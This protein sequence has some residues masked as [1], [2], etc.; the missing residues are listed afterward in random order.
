MNVL[1]G[2]IPLAGGKL[3]VC[4]SPIT[5]DILFTAARWQRALLKTA[6]IH[7]EVTAS[8]A[9]PDEQV[10]LILRI[11]PHHMPHRQGYELSIDAGTIRIIGSDN[12]G[13]FYGVCTLVQLLAQSV[14]HPIAELPCLQIVDYPDFPARGVM[15]D[16]SRDKVPTLETVYELVD[17]LAGWKINQIQLYTEHTF[18]YRNHPEPWAK[19]SPFTGEDILLLDIFCRQRFIELVP[20]QNSFG[21]MH[22]W[23]KHGKYQALA[24]CPS[25]YDY[26]WGGH[27]DEPFTLCPS[28]PGSIQLIREMYDELL[29]HFSSNMCNV[30]CDETWDLGQGRSKKECEARG[31]GRVYLDF[32]LKISKE[33]RARGKR[34]Q[35]WGD[36]ILQHP[37]LVPDL[38]KDVVALEWGYETNQPFDDHCAK[39]AAVGLDFYV[40]PGTSSWNSLAGRTDN[41]LGN[42]SSAAEN[43]KKHGAI[44]Y[45]NTDWGDSGHWQPLPVSYLGFL[46][47]AAYSWSI[48]ANRNL[49]IIGALSMFAF[50]DPT[51]NLGR[52]AYNL[53]NVY[54][55]IGVEP[56]NASALFIAL[57]N[58]FPRITEYKESVTEEQIR[59]TLK[60][61]DAAMA[62]LGDARS[63]SPDA[64]LTNREFRFSAHTLRHACYRM[65][66]AFGIEEKSK[67]ELG[68]DMDDIMREHEAVWL[69][70]NRPGGLADSMER[71]QRSKMD[72]Q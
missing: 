5:Q 41:A 42:L 65:L 62:P 23:L 12:A 47:G 63:T 67:D 30:G 69:A 24:E 68:S 18:A 15:L 53:G 40:C 13:V 56:G 8:K 50:D 14:Q 66:S 52:V 37:E 29:P 10:G 35:F 46:A 19:A 71:F 25:G 9:V 3:I 31:T 36:I 44:G 1:P 54:R 61:I 27:S 57:Q 11:D 49:D 51:G 32:L 48:D 26:P 20:N 17:R 16:I 38:P 2:G 55:S 4:E 28:D 7:W 33:V 21:H 6:N 64:D 58:P 34:M 39:F 22:R 45:L 70:R 72:Y 59:H 43:G 60:A